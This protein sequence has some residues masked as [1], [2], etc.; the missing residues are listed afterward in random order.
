MKRLLSILILI[1]STVVVL[2]SCGGGGGGGDSGSGAKGIPDGDTAQLVMENIYLAAMNNVINNA[3]AGNSINTTVNG[4]SGTATV[5]GKNLYT[6][7]FGGSNS[8]TN[9][10][11][12]AVTIEFNNFKVQSMDNITMRLNGTVKFTYYYSITTYGSGGYSSTRSIS[13]QNSTT[14]VQVEMDIYDAWDPSTLT[15]AYQDTITFS[16][17]GSYEAMLSGSCTATGGTY[18]F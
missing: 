12:V 2:V 9:T 13:I 6:Q 18:Y 1:L 11:D 15:S 4:A 8:V 10:T 14:A 3:P 17:S 5:T 16:A 7:T